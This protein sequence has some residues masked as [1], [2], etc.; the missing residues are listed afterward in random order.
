MVWQTPRTSLSPP[1]M[2]KSVLSMRLSGRPV[3]GQALAA[4]PRPVPRSVAS[5]ALPSRSAAPARP[6]LPRATPPPTSER[7][8]ALQRLYAQYRPLLEHEQLPARPQRI[9]HGDTV[10]IDPE[11]FAVPAPNIWRRRARSVDAATFAHLIDDLSQL[12]VSRRVRSTRRRARGF[13][14]SSPAV[15]AASARIARLEREADTREQVVANAR[16]HGEDVER[17]ELLGAEAELVVLG[18]PLGAHKSWAPGV[19]TMLGTAQPFVPPS[20]LRSV[21]P[22]PARSVDDV[23]VAEQDAHL[24]LTHGLVQTRVRA[25]HAWHT[26]LER[27]AHQPA[28]SLDSVRRK[29]RKKMNKHKYKKLRK[30]QRAERQR[31]KK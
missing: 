8:L 25:E 22:L 28:V 30:R 18:E 11:D 29:R 12:R 7:N 27:L 10:V 13:A 1:R 6:L 16:E 15:Q 19:A 2:R 24:W 21:P 23:D 14:P 4:A 9:V 20:A 26:A 5:P 17:A 31:L 3:V